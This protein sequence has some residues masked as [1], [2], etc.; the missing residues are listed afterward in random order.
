VLHEN[1]RVGIEKSWEM[2]KGRGHR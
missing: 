2:Q 1:H